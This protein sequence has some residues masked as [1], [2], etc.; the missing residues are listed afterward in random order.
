ML[1]RLTSIHDQ[2]KVN[3]CIIAYNALF[4]SLNSANS[5][6]IKFPDE[7]LL[8]TNSQCY[9][10]FTVKLGQFAEN[11]ADMGIFVLLSL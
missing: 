5:P 3:Y 2:L 11:N 8:N 10:R 1:R 9:D 4:A 7:Y 6:L